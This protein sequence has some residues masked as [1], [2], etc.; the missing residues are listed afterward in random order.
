MYVN[1]M[2]MA[3][4]QNYKTSKLWE[5]AT[6][7]KDD[8]DTSQK[9]PVYVLWWPSKLVLTWYNLCVAILTYPPEIPFQK[10]TKIDLKNKTS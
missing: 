10:G 5:A 1:S 9:A 4:S 3:A 2:Q 6:V 8:E 7:D